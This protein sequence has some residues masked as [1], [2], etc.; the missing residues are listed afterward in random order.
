MSKSAVFVFFIICALL[1]QPEGHPVE[2]SL[3]SVEPLGKSHLSPEHRRP[4]GLSLNAIGDHEKNQHVEYHKNRFRDERKRT[5][6]RQ[7][8]QF[9]LILSAEHE[10]NVGTD[11]SAEVLSNLWKNDDASTR[12]DA[13]ATYNR[14]FGVHGNPTDPNFSVKLKLWFL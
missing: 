14:H 1:P 4:E 2:N 9:D 11:V 13:S 10:E 6:N 5:R 3:E 8:R 12:L 7:K